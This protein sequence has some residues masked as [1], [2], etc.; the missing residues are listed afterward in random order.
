MQSSSLVHY[1][2][3]WYQT[4]RTPVGHTRRSLSRGWW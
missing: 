3:G 4:G 2:S 1:P